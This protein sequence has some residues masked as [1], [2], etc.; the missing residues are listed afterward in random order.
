MDEKKINRTLV[1]KYMYLNGLTTQFLR[2]NMTRG[3]GFQDPAH[4]QGKILSILKEHPLI[5]QKELVDQLDIKPQSASEVIR[6]LERQQLITRY[7]S[8]EDR[9]VMIIELTTKGKIAANKVGD[10]EPVAMASLTMEEK[11]QFVQILDK[12][13]LDLEPKVRRSPHRRR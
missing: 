12:L 10:F 8:S 2:E 1:E 9:R 3:H 11:Q 6:K 7:R 5:S 13:I 4:G